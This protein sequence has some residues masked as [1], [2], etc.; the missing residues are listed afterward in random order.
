[1]PVRPKRARAG[2]LEMVQ[3]IHN[4]IVVSSTASLALW[5]E[6]MVE[7]RVMHSVGPV[8]PRELPGQVSV[9]A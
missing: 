9:K 3:S 8:A 5:M 2:L 7:A 6:P 1:M 4:D